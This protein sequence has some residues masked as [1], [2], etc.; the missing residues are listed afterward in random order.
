ME[1]E[2]QRER[3]K[4]VRG[5]KERDQK[6]RK[7]VWR[8]QDRESTNKGGDV[9]ECWHSCRELIRRKWDGGGLQGLKG[10]GFC[11]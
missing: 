4:G 2:R 10:G 6:R 5:N 11:Q 3:E 8:N 9:R 7:K 1:G